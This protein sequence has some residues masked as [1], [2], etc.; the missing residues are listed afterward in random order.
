[1]LVDKESTSKL[2]TSRLLSSIKVS[3]TKV[4]E[5]LVVRSDPR[6]WLSFFRYQNC[7]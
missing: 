6:I 4:T 2:G 1:M 5:S 3:S 7:L